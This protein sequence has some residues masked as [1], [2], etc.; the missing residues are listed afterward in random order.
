[1]DQE[2]QQDLILLANLFLPLVQQVQEGLVFQLDLEV[3]QNQEAQ[4]VQWAPE[5]LCLLV[6]GVMEV[7]GEWVWVRPPHCLLIPL[8]N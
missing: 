7:Q 6:A 8:V 3:H 2:G 1:M 4:E 5:A